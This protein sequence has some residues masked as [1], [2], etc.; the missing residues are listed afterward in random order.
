MI[1]GEKA[2]RTVLQPTFRASGN[3][4]PICK[5]TASVEA[6]PVSLSL[7]AKRIDEV[8][9]VGPIWES[10]AVSTWLREL[11]ELSKTNFINYADNHLLSVWRT[12]VADQSIRQGKLKPRLS[13]S[14]LDIVHTLLKFLDLYN[15]TTETFASSELG[16]YLYQLQDVAIGRRPFRT[17]EGLFGIGPFE[18]AIGDR[19]YIISG[20]HVPYIMRPYSQTVLQFI[21]EAYVHGIMDGEAVMGCTE[22]DDSTIL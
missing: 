10:Q 20:A 22:W 18:M 21:G 15:A 6:S 4:H 3:F 9:I 17:S 14:E 8:K 11:K 12:A 2:I 16:D 7:P 1:R 19:L 13:E 5:F